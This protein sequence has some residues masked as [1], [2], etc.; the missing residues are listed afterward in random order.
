MLTL[1][2][3]LETK[4]SFEVFNVGGMA[5]SVD[6][7]ATIIIEEL[8]LDPKKVVRKYSG[9]ERGWEGDVALSLMST[10]KLES[11]GW[12]QKVSV[13]KGIRELINSI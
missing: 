9:G 12:I 1:R 7:I 2:Y 6:E 13:R 11:L 4:K 10:S 3:L 8:G 5:H